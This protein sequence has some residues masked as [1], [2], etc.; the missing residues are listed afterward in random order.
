MEKVVAIDSEGL[1]L[2]AVLHVPDRLLDGDSRPTVVLLHGFGGSKKDS[3]MQVVSAKLCDWGYVALRVD[4]RG[5]GDSEGKPGH[6]I[7]FEQVADV[8]NVITWLTARNEVDTR[9]IVLLG[10]SLGG[11]VATHTGSVDCRVAGV[12]SVGGFG[13]GAD[14]F[15]E[16]HPPPQAWERFLK[17]LSDGRRHREETGESLMV[18]RFDI[19]PIPERLRK[20]LPEDAVMQFP[21]ETAQSIYDFRPIDTIGYLAPRPLLLLHAARDAVTPTAASIAMF[22]SSGQPS[23]LI[24]LTGIDHFPLASDNKRLYEILKSWFDVYFPL[25]E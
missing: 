25:G 22:E 6:I 7:T 13:H 14:K 20:N 8:K 15:R 24:L 21:V 4:M 9:R 3:S 19:V 10:D 2:A 1:K 5:C 17:M 16:Q 18:S 12:V 11:A 23:E